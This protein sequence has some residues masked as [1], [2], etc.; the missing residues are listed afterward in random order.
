MVRKEVFNAIHRERVWQ[1]RKWGTLEERPHTV[2]EWLLI[3]E[4][5]L[6]EAKQAWV[7]GVSDLDALQELLQVAAVAVAALEQH[8]LFERPYAALGQPDIATEKL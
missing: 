8:G 4:G 5:E 1:E 6:A 2:G 3:A 7:K